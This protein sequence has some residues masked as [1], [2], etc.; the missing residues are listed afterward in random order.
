[1]RQFLAPILVLGLF[2][3]CGG[4][5]DGDVDYDAGGS[6]A[7]DASGH[8][9]SSKT[10]DAYSP[11]DDTS[12]PTDTGSG[13]KDTGTGADEGGTSCTSL[14]CT[15]DTECQ[16]ACGPVSGGIECCDTATQVC[17]STPSTTCPVT[18]GSGSDSGSG[19]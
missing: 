3:A 16:T 15:S 5:G 1:M 6:T 9:D 17:F 4:G 13:S 7:S 14:K 2:V 12:E 8:T 19:Y 10:D 18:T 11:G